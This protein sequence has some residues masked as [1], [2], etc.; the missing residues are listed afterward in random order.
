[1]ITLE[2]I[3][4]YDDN[5]YDNQLHTA[6]GFSCL[7]KLSQMT[8]LFD[9]GGDSSTLLY[10]MRQLQIE[11]REINAVVLSHIDSD[12]VGGLIG[13]LEQNSAVNVYLPH[14]FPKNFKDEV[15]LLGAKVEETYGAN[16]LFPGV[17][18]TGELGVRIIE[19]S[20]IIA[21][22]KGSVIITGCA[23][24]GI[25][26]IIRRAKEVTSDN[27]V[28]LVTGGFHLSG[29]SSAQIESIISSFIQLDVEMVA[30][31]HCSGG[32]TRRL[33]EERYGINYI[34]SGVGKEIL[35]QPAKR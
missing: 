17:Y 28:Y 22:G 8:I 1:M 19:Q 18:T 21:T 26:E 24:P 15:S 32:E 5:P 16:E 30:P 20:L 23:H 12:H 27:R 13:F 33:F 31:C 2:L 4:I 9:T 34:E 25:V 14:S 6:H 7:T 10:N 29:A 35:L 3:I 11:P